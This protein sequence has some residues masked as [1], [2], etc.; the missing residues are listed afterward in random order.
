MISPTEEM[1]AGLPRAN[2][3]LLSSPA[4]ERRQLFARAGDSRSWPQDGMCGGLAPKTS[5]GHIRRTVTPWRGRGGR[6]VDTY[7]PHRDPDPYENLISCAPPANQTAPSLKDTTRT[8]PGSR[9]IEAGTAWPL[10]TH[11]LTLHRRD[12]AF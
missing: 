5:P 3:R 10:R 4:P 11:A 8:Q 7:S 1:L 2:C 9:S 12:R 6:A